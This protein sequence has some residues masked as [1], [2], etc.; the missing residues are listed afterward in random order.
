MLHLRSAATYA[1]P[2]AEA[3][4][5]AMAIGSVTPTI[6]S[7]SVSK[8]GRYAAVRREREQ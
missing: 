4:K 1:D 8:I 7:R 5:A 3:Q 2:S 6:T